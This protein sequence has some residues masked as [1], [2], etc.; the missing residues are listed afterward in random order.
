MEQLKVRKL[1]GSLYLT[2]KKPAVDKQN[3]VRFLLPVS[4]ELGQRLKNLS[5]SGL[6]KYLSYPLILFLDKATSDLIKCLTWKKI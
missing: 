4:P 3:Y 6:L 2:Q 5:D 1:K